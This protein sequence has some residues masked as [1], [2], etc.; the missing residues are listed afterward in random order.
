MEL[1]VPNLQLFPSDLFYPSPH[2]VIA[3][4][5]LPKGKQSHQG[6][7]LMGSPL[8]QRRIAMTNGSVWKSCRWV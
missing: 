1:D 7:H 6:N 3:T 4:L 8:R 5:S 2:F